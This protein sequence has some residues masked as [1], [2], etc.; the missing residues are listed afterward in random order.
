MGILSEQLRI[1]EALNPVYN[2]LTSVFDVSG[3]PVGPLAGMVFSVKDNID[4]AGAATTHGL[5][6]LAGNVKSADA[7][8]VARLRAAGATPIGHANMPT[9][10]ARGM[11]T[12]SELAGHTINP[13]DSTLS[14]GGSSGGDAVAVATGM[15]QLGIGNDSGGSL[16]LPAF[17][18][19]VCALKPS[20]GRYPQ[21]SVLGQ[22]DPSFP[23]QVMTVEGPLARTVA[24]LRKVHGLL[25]GADPADPRAVPVPAFGAPAPRVAGFVLGDP[26]VEEAAH[27]LAQAGYEVEAVEV[28]RLDEA[29]D[30]SLRMIATP[31]ALGF[32]QFAAFAGEEVA[33]FARHLLE[34]RPGLDLAEFLALTGT[35][36]AI[37]REWAGLLDRYPVLLGPVST[38][39][40]FEPDQ[41]RRSSEALGEYFDALKLC[42]ASSFVGV[43]SVA[44][45]TGLR[46][47]LPTGVQVISRMYREDLALDAAE[48]LETPLS[49]AVSAG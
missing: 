18:N 44:V 40:S 11:H 21:G 47:G 25:C 2:A 38:I 6:S 28:P 41:D 8:I 34:V 12:Y 49:P 48:V 15:V 13:W 42:E 20:H 10:N 14:P 37:Q 30:L 32:E 16:R 29:A 31:I 17:L 27:R 5:K 4:V 1:I 26:V 24:D 3:E 35:R 33:L 39:P 19:G 43:P 36:L 7:P 46:N 22:P 9:L 23:T 45:P